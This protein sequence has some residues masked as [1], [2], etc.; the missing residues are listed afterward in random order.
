MSEFFGLLGGYLVA[1]TGLRTGVILN[2][3]VAEMKNA[4]VTKDGGRIILVSFVFFMKPNYSQNT[5]VQ[6]FIS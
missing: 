1:T 6:L 4:K 2:L 3:S 5:R